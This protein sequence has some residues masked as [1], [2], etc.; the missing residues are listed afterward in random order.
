MA[1]YLAWIVAVVGAVA[2]YDF[3][4]DN[5]VVVSLEAESGPNGWP[6]ILPLVACEQADLLRASLGLASL[7]M[8]LLTF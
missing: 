3:A 5:Y 4:A 8:T 7:M 1:S 2:A 6:T